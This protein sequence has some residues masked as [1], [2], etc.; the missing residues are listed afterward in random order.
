MRERKSI[1]RAADT[2]PK[3]ETKP[4]QLARLQLEV[5]LDIR[6]L[7]IQQDTRPAATYPVSPPPPEVKP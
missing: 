5:L 4:V 1:E 7:L 3:A 6:D 2:T